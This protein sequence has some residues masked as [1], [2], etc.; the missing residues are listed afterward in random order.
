ME[1][2]E[3]SEFREMKIT[4]A[5]IDGKNIVPDFIFEDVFDNRLFVEK[6]K[7]AV[8]FINDLPSLCKYEGNRMTIFVSEKERMDNLGLWRN[9]LLE[10][11]TGYPVSLPEYVE[12]K[13][14]CFK[15]DEG[16]PDLICYLE[17]RKGIVRVSYFYFDD[18]KQ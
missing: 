2:I 5:N 15:G 4:D 9:K 7:K 10:R 3:L 6:G 14:L 1:L 13:Y 16:N 8:G 17:A 18:E 12:H 11:L